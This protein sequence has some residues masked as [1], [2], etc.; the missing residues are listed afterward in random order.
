VSGEPAFGFVIV[1]VRLVGSPRVRVAAPKALAIVGGAGTVRVAVALLPVPPLVEV[2]GPVV[3][4]KTPTEVAVT[5]TENWQTQVSGRLARVKAIVLPP[6]VVRVPKSSKQTGVA[7]WFTTLSPAGSVWVK[8]NP[9]SVGFPS[10]LKTVKV[11]VLVPLRPTVVGENDIDRDGGVIAMVA[12]GAVMTAAIRTTRTALRNGR[13]R[14]PTGIL[15]GVTAGRM[16]RTG[17]TDAA[18]MAR[19]VQMYH[20][21]TALSSR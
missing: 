15:L 20:S 11:S 6:L 17:P 5:A 16:G 9:V 13:D 18:G 7:E 2:I 4:T 14:R 3:F 10:G 12:A 21:H 1:K 8:A 19:L